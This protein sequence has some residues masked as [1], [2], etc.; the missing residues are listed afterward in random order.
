[1]CDYV[2]IYIQICGCIQI[3][4]RLSSR[5]AIGIVSQQTYQA[6][7]GNSPGLVS[8]KNESPSPTLSPSHRPSPS[9]SQRLSHGH[10]PGPSP[11]DR[12]ARIRVLVAAFIF[13]VRNVFNWISGTH[14]HID[15]YRL[16]LLITSNA[17][18]GH[19]YSPSHSHVIIKVVVTANFQYKSF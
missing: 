15:Q 5:L 17:G 13:L 11:G 14:F 7:K 9:Q 18:H 16:F 10:S 2:H 6:V 19:S 4:H 1:M 12:H 3:I 8:V